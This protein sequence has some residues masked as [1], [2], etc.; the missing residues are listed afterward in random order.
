M[1]CFPGAV[2]QV[3]NQASFEKVERLPRSVCR[4]RRT[5]VWAYLDKYHKPQIRWEASPFML[6]R[7]IFLL[8]HDAG[9]IRFVALKPPP[10]VTA[11]G[12]AS[13]M[14][15]AAPRRLWRAAC[16]NIRSTVASDG[17][18]ARTNPFA[19]RR[20]PPPSRQRDLAPV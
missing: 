5:H 13:L 4:Q 8:G 16:R 14:R 6:G 19:D 12:G 10:D 11:P 2:P 15:A 20:A 17:G 1:K 7:V 9:S 3:C 18:A